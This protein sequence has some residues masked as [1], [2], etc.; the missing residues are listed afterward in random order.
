MKMT[1]KY[2]GG[3]VDPEKEKWE[4]KIGLIVLGLF[5]IVFV[6]LLGRWLTN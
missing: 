5:L 1:K 3:F 2:N 6:V 4:M